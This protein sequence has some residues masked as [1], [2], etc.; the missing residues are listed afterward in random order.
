MKSMKKIC[1]IHGPNLNFTGIR[2]KGVYGTQT[3][4]DINT[5]ILEKAKEME[6]D[7]EVFQ[8]NYEGAIIDKLQQCYHESF[9][10]I[11]IN[12]G[13]FTHYSYAI[14]DAIASVSIPTVEVHLSNV[15]KRE[16]FRTIS[17]TAPV[18]IGQMCGFGVNGYILA[19]NALKMN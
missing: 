6:L 7:V 10:G 13:A 2:E 17:V 9:D 14:R 12:P 19:M 11:I 4:E 8:S 16:E 5:F 3:L 18:C 15:H 1:V